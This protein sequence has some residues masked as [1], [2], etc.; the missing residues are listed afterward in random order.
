MKFK[1]YHLGVSY[2][3]LTFT[4]ALLASYL[5]QSALGQ[6]LIYRLHEDCSLNDDGSAGIKELERLIRTAECNVKS[7]DDVLALLPR[8]MRERYLLVYRSQSLQGPHQIDFQNPRVILSTTFDF[9]SSKRL[10]MSFNGDPK[11]AN[12]NNL[13]VLEVDLS[14]PSEREDIFNYF[15]IEFPDDQTAREL[16]WEVAQARIK[17]SEPN[18]QACRTCHGSPAKPI[19]Q[20]Y[21]I[22]DGIYG[23]FHL[24]I[25]EVEAKELAQFFSNKSTSSKRYR[26]LEVSE[27]Y[28][29]DVRGIL[30]GE[31]S[32][33]F[34]FSLSTA[35]F[36]RIARQIRTHP[37][38]DK[39]R[40][41]AI[42]AALN[43]VNY[44]AF[45]TEDVKQAL[46]S[47]ILSKPS[48]QKFQ[49]YERIKEVFDV[50]FQLG[51]NQFGSIFL[52][53]QEYTSR[54]LE[55]EDGSNALGTPNITPVTLSDFIESTTHKVQHWPAM[56][57]LMIDTIDR[58]GPHRADQSVAKLR[59]L[60]EGLG[61]DIQDWFM[62]L[63]QPTYRM[64]DGFDWAR[65]L[66]WA[67]ITE[68]SELRS[69]F[70]PSLHASRD[71]SAGFYL[72][73]S[74]A[75]RN[76]SYGPEGNANNDLNQICTDLKKES[77]EQFTI[78]HH[79]IQ[80]PPDRSLSPLMPLN[81]DNNYPT[82]FT[83]SCAGCHSGEIRI[84]PRIPFLNHQQFS[85]WI[86]Q[87]PE[88]NT[89]IRDRLTTTNNLD[90]MPPNRDLEDPELHAIFQYLDSLR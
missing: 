11:Q 79:K 43:C 35:N 26:H 77:R 57:Q 61:I 25:D 23:S 60:F 37:M 84:G 31:V 59:Y 16:S 53:A 51:P 81:K 82:T 30:T 8:Q 46:D 70:N 4:L 28:G 12:H 45:F 5:P 64:S 76:E 49:N 52:D 15:D 22:W 6:Q 72:A 17:S 88:R 48:I 83:Q 14:R 63:N 55:L 36:L 27:K 68:D 18:P 42:G 69:R 34:N 87:S 86:Q 39:I 7:I 13:E 78:S 67:L 3:Y 33:R 65:G 58:Q 47:T 90:R 50:H 74:D 32:R 20:A 1:F 40:S 54:K 89:I 9:S 66:A 2:F 44:D 19:F 75:T 56:M 38:Y 10:F 41:P 73:R 24:G 29:F 62:D 85:A 80:T 21:P 71:L